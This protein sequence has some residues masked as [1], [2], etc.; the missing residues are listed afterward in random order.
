MKIDKMKQKKLIK[1]DK[2]IIKVDKKFEEDNK[3]SINTSLTKMLGNLSGRKS[4]V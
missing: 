2:K 3:P 1:I 4:S